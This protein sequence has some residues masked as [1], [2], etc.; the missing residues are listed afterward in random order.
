MDQQGSRG[1]LAALVKAV[2]L[3]LSSYICADLLSSVSIY[4][5]TSWPLCLACLA[6]QVHLH[7]LNCILLEKNSNPRWWTD[8][9][10]QRLRIFSKF[11]EY[12]VNRCITRTRVLSLWGKSLFEGY[13]GDT[14]QF[15]APPNII[16]FF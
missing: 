1:C 2:Q 7:S 14:F 16:V 13:T 4:H 10:L 8:F 6:L 15:P 5:S 3:Y 11:E 12:K 9:N